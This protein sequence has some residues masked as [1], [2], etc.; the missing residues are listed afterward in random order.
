MLTPHREPVDVHRDGHHYFGV[1]HRLPRAV[2]DVSG[3]DALPLGAA[4]L[5]PDLHLHLA[6]LER[7]RD[8]RALG[9]RQV[10]LAV[11]LLL[12]LEQLLAGERGPSAAALARRAAGGQRLLRATLEFALLGQRAARVA[13]REALVLAVRRAVLAVAARGV[14]RL[15]LEL[16]VVGA[17][18][19]GLG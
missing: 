7:V 1:P 13:V 16:L 17:V 15:E 6:E 10:L 11:E 4:V 8:L 12:Q 14:R 18:Q 3:L 2:V 19:F 9:E 5:E